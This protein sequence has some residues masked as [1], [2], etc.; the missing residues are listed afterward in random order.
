MTA[1]RTEREAILNM[2]ENYGQ[3]P[4]PGALSYGNSHCGDVFEFPVWACDCHCS[5]FRQSS[6]VASGY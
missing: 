6:S 2:I 3:V 5:V 4:P 1:W